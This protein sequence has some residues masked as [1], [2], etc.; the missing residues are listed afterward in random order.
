MTGK[1]SLFEKIIVAATFAGVA[2]YAYAVPVSFDLQ[3]ANPAT[4][5]FRLSNTSVSAEILDFPRRS[6][7][8]V[9]TLIL[10]PT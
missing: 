8:R 5:I 7:I 3:I 2:N 4:S 9:R 10:Y 1:I 6:G